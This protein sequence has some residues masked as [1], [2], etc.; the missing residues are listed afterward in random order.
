M[1][2]RDLPPARLRIA[3][4]VLTGMIARAPFLWPL[5]RRP[6]RSFF[7]RLAPH[8]DE[9]THADSP[10]RFAPLAAALDHVANPPGRILDLGTGTGAAA[11]ALARRYPE[12]RV[13]GVDISE[14]MITAARAKL[15]GTGLGERVQ[16]EVADI[17]AL[18]HPDR[19]FDLVAQVSTPVF[20]DEIVRVL[21]PFGH[22]AIVSSLGPATPFHTSEPVLERGFRRRGLDVVATGAA[23][24]GTFLLARSG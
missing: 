19:E 20:F 21:A 10:E 14:P 17:A 16:F 4:Q 8:W 6:T 12:A 13:L 22:V 1:S 15:A 7:D 18:P 24:R 23:G 9:R 5:L 3:G 11:L 2:D